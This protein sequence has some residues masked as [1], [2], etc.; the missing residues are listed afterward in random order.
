MTELEI[1]SRDSIYIDKINK[2]HKYTLEEALQ[3]VLELNDEIDY[4]G[5]PD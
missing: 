5:L 3:A 1:S 2:R 4:S